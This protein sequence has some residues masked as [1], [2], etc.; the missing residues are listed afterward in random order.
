MYPGAYSAERT[1][2]WDI[3]RYAWLLLVHRIIPAVNEHG[4]E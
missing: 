2:S 3:P 1:M 4:P